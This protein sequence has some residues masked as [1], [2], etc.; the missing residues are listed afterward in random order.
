MNLRLTT[1]VW[2][3]SIASI[4]ACLMVA[5]CT[6][7]ICVILERKRGGGGISAC[8]SCSAEMACVM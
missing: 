3:C 2:G 6:V 8:K 4:V 1:Y 7:F 5:A